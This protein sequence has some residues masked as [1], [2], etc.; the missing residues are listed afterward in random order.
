MNSRQIECFLEAGKLLN[1]TKAA[2]NLMLPQPAVSRYISSLEEELGAKLFVRESSR[3]ILLSEAGKEYYNLFQHFAKEFEHTRNLLSGGSPSLHLGYNTGWNL[4]AFLPDVVQ[5]CRQLLP[6][7]RIH[8][9]CLDFRDLIQGLNEKRLDAVLSMENYLNQEPDLEI[10]RITSVRRY[11]VYSERLEGYETLLSPEDFFPYYFFLVDD[12]RV[13]QIVHETETVFQPYHF[14]PRFVT[15]RNLDT[16]FACVE[17][18]L[19]VAVL[20]GW[21]G[22][23]HAPGIRAM[24]MGDT[25]SVALAR[26]KNTKLPTVELLIDTLTEELRP[27]V[28]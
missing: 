4:S 9:E 3:R 7:F 21:Y 2:E 10:E 23:L 11:I 20:D 19:G 5:R 1:F 27:G 22:N 14:V 24:D 6:D 8:L 25:I 18:G 16:V 13:Q 17:N 26:K 12:S 15:V 28:Q